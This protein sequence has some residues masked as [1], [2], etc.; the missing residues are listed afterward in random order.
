MRSMITPR[1]KPLAFGLR[2]PSVGLFVHWYNLE[3]RHSGIRYV[4]PRQNT[5]HFHRTRL[6]L[7]FCS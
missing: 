3:H 2:W 7:T 5:C 6:F 4:P 1:I